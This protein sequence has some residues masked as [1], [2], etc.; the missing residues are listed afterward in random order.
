MD[1]MTDSS[2]HLFIDTNVFLSFFAFTNDDVE[3]LRKLTK[4]FER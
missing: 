4:R 1:D 2:V 3:Q